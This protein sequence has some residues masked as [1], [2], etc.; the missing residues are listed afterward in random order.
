MGDFVPESLVAQDIN[1][2]APVRTAVDRIAAQ[3][4][5][6]RFSDPAVQWQVRSMALQTSRTS[7]CGRPNLCVD[8]RL[9]AGSRFTRIT[10]A[11]ERFSAM[12]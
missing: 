1:A 12:G 10:S 4:R 5:R 6:L 3:Q 8:G 2:F 11:G 7:R 9:L